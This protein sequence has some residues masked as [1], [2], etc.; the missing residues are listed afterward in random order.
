MS[1]KRPRPHKHPSPD[2]YHPLAGASRAL[3]GVSQSLEPERALEPERGYFSQAAFYPAGRLPAQPADVARPLRV[4]HVGQYMV[5]AG[6]E[7]W[8]K[9]LIRLA[10]PRRLAFQR[11]VVTSPLSDRRVIQDM[12]VPVEVGGARSVRRAAQDC[13]VLLISG[14]AEV[15]GWL[16][17]TRPPVCVV[18]AHGETIWSRLILEGCSQVIDHVVAVSRSVRKK[19]CNGFPCSVIYNGCDTSHLTRTTPRDEFRARFGLKPDDFVVG[20][21]MRLTPGKN[22]EQLIEAI[23][24]LPRRFKLFLVGWGALQQKLLHLANE[25]APLRCVIAAAE[26]DLGDYYAAFDAFCLPSESEGFG[27]ATLEA[28]FSGVPVV[29]TRTGFPP[30][31]LTSGVHYLQSKSTPQSLA[32]AL[33]RLGKHPQ[34]AAGLAAQGRRAAEQFGFATRMCREYEDLL[35]KLWKKSGADQE[36]S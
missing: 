26:E 10:D 22:P 23:A 27:L 21:V 36:P 2:R 9:A 19:V 7:I 4:I 28:M 8:L 3:G 16:G 6:I 18:V 17:T 34:W 13:D 14:P 31:L 24:R 1:A 32:A 33:A 5:R 29:T 12:P 20:S 25:I 35:I 11:C 15:A 30:E